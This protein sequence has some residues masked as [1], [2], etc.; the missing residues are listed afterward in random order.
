MEDEAPQE[1]KTDKPLQ[2]DLIEISGALNLQ[3]QDG[4]DSKKLVNVS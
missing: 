1:E 4:C 2:L 3:I